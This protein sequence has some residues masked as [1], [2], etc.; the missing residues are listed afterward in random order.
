MGSR[1]SPKS[2]ELNP[3]RQ[4]GWVT[5]RNGGRRVGGR[6]LSLLGTM[7]PRRLVLLG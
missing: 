3:G 4:L 1:E 6:T 7:S 2:C 5:D